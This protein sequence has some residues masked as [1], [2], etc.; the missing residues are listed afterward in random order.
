MAFTV[1]QK[2][3][4]VQ[5]HYP[6]TDNIAVKGNVFFVA[7]PDTEPI[8]GWLHS[9]IGTLWI[10]AAVPVSVC[11]ALR[12][13]PPAL[14]HRS[15]P[16]LHA[17]RRAE[18]VVPLRAPSGSADIP[19]RELSALD[20]SRRG[21]SVHHCG[22]CFHFEIEGAEKEFR[23]MRTERKTDKTIKKTD[24]FYALTDE[25]GAIDYRVEC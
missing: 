24:L 1:A 25:P 22:G 4:K 21:T 15:G 14:V 17:G 23:A 11:P 13:V 3:D 8:I 7:F 10:K 9:P 5:L 2:R 12:K 20:H 18:E 16:A 6:T 19:V